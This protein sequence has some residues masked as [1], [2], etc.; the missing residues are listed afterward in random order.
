MNREEIGLAVMRGLVKRPRLAN[1][2]FKLD[3][4]GNIMGPD[5]WVNP[6]PIYERMRESGPVSF[7]PFFQQWAVVG[8]EEAREVLSSP[9]FGVADQLE[10]LLKA[11][12]YS[13]LADATKNLL[14]NA[15]LMTDP[16]LHTRLRSVVNRAFTPKQMARLEPRITEITRDLLE[17]CAGDATPDLVKGFAAPLPINVISELLGVPEDRWEWVA[18]ISL[19][20]RQILDPFNPVDPA[21][22]D[23]TVHELT[24]Y[25]SG[26]ADDRLAAPRDDLITVFAQSETGD[27]PIDRAELVSLIA[28]IML[29]GHETIT[30]ALGNAIVAL[31]EN[32][33]QRTLVRDNP[34]LWP[35]AVEELLRFDTVLQTDARAALE[36]VTIAGQ[37]IKKGQNLTVMLGAV[38]RDPRRWDNP[39][40]LQLDRLDPSP[41]SFGHGIHHC[42]GAA[43]ARL[44]MR[45]GLQAVVETF[46]DYT[47]DPA[48][49]T[50][51]ES[52]AF[53]GP[54]Y[55]PVV[56]GS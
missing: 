25:Y 20:L 41:L 24:E 52:L 56:A 4:W 51:R 28:I 6:Y 19:E 42:I 27:D 17:A 55:L 23:A 38:N 21:S 54:D 15:L 35:N 49:V 46:G 34:E 47:V 16:P 33:K 40:K 14:R 13:E 1:A 37:T 5:R 3:K 53:R 50:W 30:G 9:S 44:Q 29:A 22:V 31:A 11:R 10:L 36:T 8:Y 26:L 12:P 45:I 43:L 39:N 7:S 18:R 48:Q 32:P 2:A